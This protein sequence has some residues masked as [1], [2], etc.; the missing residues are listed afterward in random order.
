MEDRY[1]DSNGVRIHYVDEGEGDPIVL[2]HGFAASLQGNWVAAGWFDTLR[3]LRRIIA[4]DCRGHGLSDKPHESSHYA[5][6]EMAG[7]IARLMDHLGIGRADLFG[8]SMG[9]AI[10]I[11]A[12]VRYPDRFRTVTLGGVGN[13]AS[14]RRGR[15]G[16]AA[17]LRASDGSA[18]TD[19]VG[20]GFRQFAERVGNNDLEALA[21]MQSAERGTIDPSALANNELP[22]L[23]VVGE[24]DAIVGDSDK[25][26]AA[27]NG[28][29]L[30]TIPGKDH[31][32]VV[33]DQRFKDAVVSFLQ[34]PR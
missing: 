34:E 14:G 31:L 23:I 13:L 33:P 6:D 22:V 21:A 27:I 18:V 32:T 25:L 26:A 12:M 3:P 24:K 5:M 7:D 30:V 17:A 15:P 4:L 2:V 1:F 10:S 8:Y 9:G 16:I 20:R 19:A 11:R 29:R 28:A